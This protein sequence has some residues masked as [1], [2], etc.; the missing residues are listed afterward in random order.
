MTSSTFG[1]PEDK[2]E[3]ERIEV[4]KEAQR[5]KEYLL[6]VM[7]FPPGD[8]LA[9]QLAPWCVRNKIPLRISPSLGD[10]QTVAFY[11]KATDETFQHIKNRAQNYVGVVL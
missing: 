6:T 1:Q 8:N 4:A 3:T 2:A 11:I 7:S 10:H 9:G 5:E